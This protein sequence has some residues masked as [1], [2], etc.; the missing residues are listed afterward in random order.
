MSKLKLLKDYDAKAPYTLQM[1]IID[2]IDIATVEFFTFE[3]FVRLSVCPNKVSV[4]L[5]NIIVNF[6]WSSFSDSVFLCNYERNW[7]HMPDS[8]LHLNAVRRP[9]GC[10]NSWKGWKNYQISQ[11]SSHIPC[12]QN[13]QA[14]CWF[15]ISSLH[16]STSIQRVGITV[17][18]CRYGD[19][20]SSFL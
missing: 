1:Q 19:T 16:S 14:F 4:Y 8:F 5:H 7:L 2:T 18:H 13:V 17:A 15:T 11:N 12:V 10:G 9:R 3:Y 20:T 6:E